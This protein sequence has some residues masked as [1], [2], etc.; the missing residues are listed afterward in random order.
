M[1]ILLLVLVVAG[2][3]FLSL[4]WWLGAVLRPVLQDRG[5]TFERYERA[6]YAHFRLHGVQYTSP[7][8][9]FTA[10]Q[11]QSLTPLAWLGQRLRG[12]EPALMVADWQAR[13]SAG[14]TSSAAEKK[15]SGLLDLQSAVQRLGP[16]VGYWLPQ[17]HL[18]AGELSG[19]GPDL[20][21]AQ[22]DW[23]NSTL[24]VQGL[25]VADHVLAFTIV[26]ATDGTIVLTAH[27]ADNAARLRLVWSG[28]DLKG[29][30][31]LWDQTAQLSAR[32]PSQG[33]LPAEA[34]IVAEKWRLPAT[35]VKL[36]VPYAQVLGD[37][38]LIWRDG[39]FDLSLTA[40]A[41]PSADTKAPPLEASA[42]AHG[43][44]REL[45]LTAL[46]V[47]A[48]FATAKLSAPITFSLDRPLAA[49]SARLS[50]QADLA[51]MPW[52]EAR[53]KVE[54]T[55]NV[56]GD[57]A[58]A[59]QTFELT[60]REVVLGEVDIK[61]AQARGTLS[62]PQ[63][64]VTELKVQLDD[65][66]ALESHGSINWQTRELAG[67]AL[68]AKLTPAS[69]ARW[70]PKG[71]TWATAEIA[72][73]AEGPLAAPRHEGSVKVVGAHHPPL[74]PLTLAVAW[75]GQGGQTEITAR[76]TAKTSVLEIAGALDAQG[77][78]V[79]RFQLTPGGQ[80]GWQLSAPARITWSPAWAIDSFHVAGPDS[81]LTLKGKGG[82]DGSFEIAATNFSSAWLQDWLTV[83]GPGWQLRSLRAT[84]Q[85]KD[86]VVVFE[87]ALTAQIEMS[88]RPAEV[89]LMAH[90]DAHGIELK[91]LKVVESGR[92]LTQAVGRLPATFVMEPKPHVLFDETAS[93]E[94]TAS[95]E[96]DSPLWATLTA[97]TGLL[98]TQ[99]AARVDLHGTL[100][101]PVGELQVKVAR[102]GARPDQFNFPL[103][104][105][106]ELALAMQFG[107][108]KITVTNFSAKLDGQAVQASGLLPMGDTGWQQ[109]WRAPKDF[110]WS[111]A[112]A[113]VEIPDADLAPLAR[114]FPKLVAAQGRLRAQ[115]ELAPGGNFSGEL[116]LSGAASRPLSALGSL[117]E[118][119]AAVLLADRVITIQKMTAVLGGEPLTLDG[120]VTLVPGGPPSL[121]L[122]LK[123]INLPLVRNTGLL[124]RSDVELHA[125]T[126]PAGITRLSGALTVRDCLV[127][128]SLNLR[129]LLPSGR[130]G[131]TRQPPYFAVPVEP[132]RD[133]PLAVE[134]RAPRAVR[135]RTT[136]YNGVASGFFQLGG[137]LGEPRA[138][139][140][141]TVDQGQVLFPFATF[142]VQQGAV[143]LS[144]AD[145][146][147]AVVSL[148]A[149]SQ[150][151]DYQMRL[152]V[153]GELPAPNVTITS[154]P[155][156][157]AADVLLMVMTGQSPATDT[158]VG[159]T[160]SGGQRLALLGAY[161]SR[162]LFQ[163]LGL[164]GE[165]RLEISAGEH[166]SR[167]GR[168]TYEFEYKLGERWSL[169]GEYD[170]FDA[171]NAGLKWRVYTEE[172]VPL[173]KKK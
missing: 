5:I 26:P 39:A 45:T 24:S 99:P 58:A 120:T 109:L 81:Q 70:L 128:A 96:P 59:R 33:W 145:P 88:P 106:D 93:L 95:T 46:H 49:E 38:R 11:V 104:D 101:Q 66:S 65:G 159:R 157:E 10:R 27:T 12:A 37:G 22:V 60:F 78:Q 57:S 125:N 154:S 121:A 18:S 160:G 122:A 140:Q 74:H 130:R 163:D 17:A 28:A 15:L 40:K 86:R 84:G 19:F 87:A 107:R 144:E 108:E 102:L 43:N 118:I 76:A 161:L 69:L 3:G 103:P 91:E 31:V 158:V 64:E 138:V 62:W 80:P 167:Q 8:F 44:L 134:I 94:L 165:D 139:G 79:S 25:H 166:I 164:G 42:T 47:D 127:L 9:V 98:L 41:E 75:T 133:W 56:T 14:S 115:V 137:T 143:R 172:G 126:N 97:Y 124:L 54:G 169:T 61:S 114:R 36:G 162:G 131:V 152:E 168:E 77:A 105:F 82:P 89:T 156:L 20:K 23:Q 6:G 116:H 21:V 32:F 2:V 147:H 132:F 50:V 173:E 53:G 85:V 111:K 100:R 4:P 30:A 73:T 123:G 13:R 171:Y 155:A 92:V 55:V 148:N 136:V 71:T 51:K 117:Q 1:K 72:A 68:I 90:G 29:E 146:F 129:T 142:T 7:G 48:P 149:T 52:F 16:R 150:R 151:R 113:R 135:V 170:E 110:D 141:L 35:R 112:A 63:L 83:T 34:S 153:T 67:V 119:N